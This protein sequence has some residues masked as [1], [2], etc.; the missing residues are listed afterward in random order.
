MSTV[1]IIQKVTGDF[2]N[3]ILV[4][5]V[6]FSSI[7]SSS[8]TQIELE[9]DAD[10]TITATIIGSGLTFSAGEVTGG[11][12]TSVEIFDGGVSIVEITGLILAGV[13]W[14]DAVRDARLGDFTAFDALID[15]APVDYSAET[16]AAGGVVFEATSGGDRVTGSAG[17][18]TLNPG[19]NSDDGDFIRGSAGDDTII[20]SQSTPGSSYQGLGYFAFGAAEGITATID[21]TSNTATID[22]GA[23][24]V[25]TIVDISN[26]LTSGGGGFGIEGTALGDVFNLSTQDGQFLQVAGNAGDDTFNILTGDVRI[27]YAFVPGQINVDLSTGTASDDGFGDTDTFTGD[28]WEIRGSDFADVIVGSDNDESFIGREGDDFIDGGGGEDRLRFNRPGVSDVIVD[29]Q[30]GTAT[31]T[32]NGNAFNYTIANIE[33]IFGGAG[34]DQLFGDDGTNEFNGGDG[35]DLINPGDNSDYDFISGSR[36]DDTIVYSQSTNGFQ[37]IGYNFFGPTEG[38]AATIDGL[39]NVATVNKGAAGID[40]F[41]NIVN[42]LN[43]GGFGIEGTDFADTFNISNDPDQWMRIIGAAG[44]DFFNIGSG[45]VRLD[46]R[47][48]QNGIE[49]DLGAGS[50]V[51]D[52]FGDTD[53]INGNL[54]EIRASNHADMLI[55]SD[56]DESFIGLEGDDT[57]D[58]RGGFDRVR[59]DEGGAADVTVDLNAGT[60]TGNWNGNA[61]A[62]NLS[63]IER[64]DGSFGDDVLIGSDDEVLNGNSGNDEI[65]GGDGTD[66]LNG[67][68]GDD[69][70]TPGSNDDF[71]FIAGSTGN[72]SI[73]YSQSTEG[74]QGLS[75]RF[76]GATSGL[77]ATF[78]G[79]ANTATV[80]KG[81]DGLDTITDIVN[82][83]SNGG[84]GIEGTGL[85][86][87]FNIANLEDQW[88]QVEGGAGDDTIN[89]TSGL[90]RLDYRNAAGGVHV[91][92]AAGTTTDDGFGDTDT[93]TG[94]IA[95]VRGSAFADTIVANGGSH[96]FTGGDE[97]DTVVYDGERS[98]FGHDLQDDGSILVDKT[99]G[100]TDTLIEVE[101]IDFT[102]GDLIYDLVSPNAGLVYRIY[103]ASFDRTPDEGGLRFWTGVADH[104]VANEPW[105]DLNTFLADQ[106]VGS[107][108]FTQLYGA[109]PSNGEFVD[110]MY[111]NV[112][113]RLPDQEGRDYWVGLMDQG[114]GREG[115]LIQFAESNENRDKTAADLDDG[116]WVV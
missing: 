13:G 3:D 43:G 79:A 100:D 67:G 108:E 101:R 78:D 88:M 59:F 46:F 15:A 10:P 87:V 73:I 69:T 18:D 19:D 80:D 52:G 37:S 71:D 116:I 90:V 47:R 91:D 111:L 22:K 106:F 89:V 7:Q 95:D 20:Y 2:Y 51:D 49:V 39:A 14:G 33:R 76:Y 70:L 30:A 26:P 53:T 107:D 97:H 85:A 104:V 62:Y 113:D 86:D 50:V 28:V 64:I 96:E 29:L 12:I 92:L 41:T 60:A 32:W 93:F 1:N 55:G 65:I 56:N 115:V 82:P 72:D 75:Y 45:L 94:F 98:E 21:G 66:Q 24:G 105:R 42:P 110:A 57:I 23:A 44:D 16:V 40:N 11:T 38:V 74:Y 4:P 36:G 35:N 99:G 83:I 5:G 27:D 114:Y 81:A 68:G 54:W 61:F 102:D 48:A 8:S 112:L 77:V 25:D 58:G 17:S 63:N 9:N 103:E 6:V 84:F 109:D 31:G 34:N